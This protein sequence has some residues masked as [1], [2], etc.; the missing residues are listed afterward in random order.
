MNATRDDDDD[1]DDDDDGSGGVV[2]VAGPYSQW[3]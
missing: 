1:D 3:R 2:G